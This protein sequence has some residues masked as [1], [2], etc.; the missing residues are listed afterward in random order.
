MQQTVTSK[1]SL[2]CD[3]LTARNRLHVNPKITYLTHFT[4]GE[5]PVAKTESSVAVCARATV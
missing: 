5:Q 3:Q 2:F 1:Q 4:N